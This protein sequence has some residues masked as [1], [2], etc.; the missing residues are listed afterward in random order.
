MA[1]KAV[2]AATAGNLYCGRP[3]PELPGELGNPFK[4]SQYERE[5][6]IKLYIQLALPNVTE[7]QKQK[8]RAA[9]FV[10][11][12]CEHGSAC[13]TDSLIDAALT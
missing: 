12:Y 4:V 10:G 7:V 2:W 13:H 5:L 6:A 3:F 11:C 9:S 1:N 8:V